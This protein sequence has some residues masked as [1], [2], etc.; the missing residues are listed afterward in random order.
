MK[1]RAFVSVYIKKKNTADKT[2]MSKTGKHFSIFI[3]FTF[4]CTTA[5]KDCSEILCVV[6]GNGV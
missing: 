3:C 1:E 6:C 2:I 4:I 5:R